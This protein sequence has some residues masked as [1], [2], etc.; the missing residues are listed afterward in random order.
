MKEKDFTVECN[1]CKQHYVNWTGSTPC[2]GSLAFLVNEDGNTSK[3]ISLFSSVGTVIL[4][5]VKNDSL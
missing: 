3:K 2:C 5:F 1:V 4:D